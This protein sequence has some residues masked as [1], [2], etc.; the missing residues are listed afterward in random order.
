M[1]P[2]VRSRLPILETQHDHLL[3]RVWILHYL[4]LAWHALWRLG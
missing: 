3:I 2:L 4:E 1:V